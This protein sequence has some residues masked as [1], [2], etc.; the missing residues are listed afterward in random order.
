MI[1]REEGLLSDFS[2]LKKSGGVLLNQDDE[3]SK[4]LLNCMKKEKKK[5]NKSVGKQKEK[6]KSLK[7][8]KSRKKNYQ[9][10]SERKDGRRE[11]S[12]NKDLLDLT[13]HKEP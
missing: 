12:N 10:K 6:R 1:P 13:Q 5:L 3:G 9:S 11:V 2:G 8:N 7:K 4:E